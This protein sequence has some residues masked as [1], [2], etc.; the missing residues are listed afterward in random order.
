MIKEI[1]LLFEPKKGT[2]VNHSAMFKH[3][4]DNYLSETAMQFGGHISMNVVDKVGNTLEP[5]WQYLLKCTDETANNIRHYVAMNPME[6]YYVHVYT[7]EDN[8]NSK[9]MMVA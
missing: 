4:A 8:E 2:C 6:G 9:H 3:Y 1:R 7:K 5:V